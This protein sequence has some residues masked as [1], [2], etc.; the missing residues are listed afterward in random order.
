MSP[1]LSLHSLHE[2]KQSRQFQGL[3]LGIRLLLAG[4]LAWQI[5]SNPLFSKVYLDINIYIALGIY[6]V[7]SLLHYLFMLF[8][9]TNAIVFYLGIG[10]DWLFALSLPFLLPDQA[11]I[12]II[13]A[14]TFVI[15]AFSDLRFFILVALTLCYLASALGA[16]YVFDTLSA[17]QLKTAHLMSISIFGLGYLNY[18]KNYLQHSATEFKS[19]L[20]PAILQKKHLIEGLGYLFPFHHRNQIP[21]SILMIRIESASRNN[22]D[23]G[24]QL[25]TAY[26]NRLRKCDLFVQ[27]DRQHLAILLCDTSS[28]QAS[29]LVKDL[30]RIKNELDYPEIQLNFGICTIPLDQEIALDDLLTQ[31]MHTLHEAE[32]QKVQRLIFINAK[33]SD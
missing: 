21:M 32:L 29:H 14:I 2:L 25:I 33:Q 26:K 11:S 24:N 16:G 3:L 19:S 22:K 4:T 5:F 20:N 9:P 13:I 17:S 7:L 6:A 1:L 27:L 30:M 31:M 10:V 8:R 23:F 28:T 18:F 15:A 12:A